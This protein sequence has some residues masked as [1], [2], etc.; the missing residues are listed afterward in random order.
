MSTSSTV[1]RGAGM[2]I[3]TA[4]T[5]KAMKIVKDSKPKRRK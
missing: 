4:A 3:T 1:I 5:L 2:Y